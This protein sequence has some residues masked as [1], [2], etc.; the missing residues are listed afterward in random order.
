LVV[1]DVDDGGLEALMELDQLG[2]ELGAHFGVEVGE[3]FVEEEDAGLPD[4]GAP[5]GDALLLSTGEIP[6]H[7]GEKIFDAEN[8]SGFMDT[9]GD[10]IG[11]QMA[12]PEP[13]SE[14]LRNAEVRVEG[15][16]L[17]DHGDIAFTGWEL[18]DVGI[19]N[20]DAAGGETLKAGDHAQGAGLAATGG[21]EED[22]ERFVGNFEREVEDGGDFLAAAAAVDLGDVLEC[23]AGHGRGARSA[24][25]PRVGGAAA[26]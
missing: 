11:R 19:T 14:I 10:V 24:A 6:W 12:D 25:G 1:G 22:D 15:V 20:K 8:R 4:N 7:P 23:D 26:E 5:D 17:E 3:R 18:A 21:P 16:I 9:A 13:E 2:T